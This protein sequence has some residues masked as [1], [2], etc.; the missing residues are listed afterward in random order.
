LHEQD[1]LLELELELELPVLPGTIR[2]ADPPDTVPTATV[3]QV[4]TVLQLHV[5]IA[6]APMSEE[7]IPVAVTSAAVATSLS[8]KNVFIPGR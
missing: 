7:T 4:Q 5:V 1:E 2:N 8:A 6:P 3:L